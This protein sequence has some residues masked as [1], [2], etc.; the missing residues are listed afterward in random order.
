[1]HLD[2]PPGGISASKHEARPGK[3]GAGLPC[4]KKKKMKEK[5]KIS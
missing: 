5:S 2:S 4:M 3:S 1:M